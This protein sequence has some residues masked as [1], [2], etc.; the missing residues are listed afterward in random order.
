VL[1]G[2][3][4]GSTVI[5]LL[6]LALAALVTY[7]ITRWRLPHRPQSAAAVYWT[8][9]RATVAGGTVGA[10]AHLVSMFAAMG[11]VPFIGLSASPWWQLA[12]GAGWG[13][14]AGL[15]TGWAAVLVTRSSRRLEGSP[16]LQP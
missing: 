7:A 12:Y 13:G 4:G 9:W 16:P 5:T 15:L 8:C 14:L 6:P 3:R 1:P 10:L 11:L 2:A